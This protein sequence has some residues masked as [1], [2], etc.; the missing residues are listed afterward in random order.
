MASCGSTCKCGEGDGNCCKPNCEYC[1]SCFSC[2]CNCCAHR[3]KG[4]AIIFGI[5]FLIAIILCVV[6]YMKDKRIWP[7]H[8]LNDYF[9]RIPDIYDP[10]EKFPPKDA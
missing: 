4:L 1:K 2:K 8:K 3:R 6:Y 7:F 9:N 5:L 10:Y